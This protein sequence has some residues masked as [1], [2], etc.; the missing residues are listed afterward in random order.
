MHRDFLDDVNR[1]CGQAR[2][3]ETA[4]YGCMPGSRTLVDAFSR[5]LRG[6]Q[7]ENCG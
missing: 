1:R 2:Q 7:Q 6:A 3:Q 4:P 5:R